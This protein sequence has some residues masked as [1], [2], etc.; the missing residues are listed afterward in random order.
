MFFN[1]KQTAKKTKVGTAR[2]LSSGSETERG[3]F[4]FGYL[5]I[6]FSNI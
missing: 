5:L 4:N 3:L 6:D 1:G 2:R